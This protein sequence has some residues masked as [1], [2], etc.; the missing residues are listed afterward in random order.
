MCVTEQFVRAVFKFQLIYCIFTSFLALYIHKHAGQAYMF[1]GQRAVSLVR[2]VIGLVIILINF[3]II[4]I[5][6]LF[7]FKIQQI[8]SFH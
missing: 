1:V 3:T 5:I 7:N 8:C 4:F 6:L 2:S